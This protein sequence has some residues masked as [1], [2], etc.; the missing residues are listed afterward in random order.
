MTASYEFTNFNLT[1]FVLMWRR[2]CRVH[3]P[4]LLHHHPQPLLVKLL[5]LSLEQH[6]FQPEVEPVQE[7]LT[8]MIVPAVLAYF[9]KRS[10]C[11]PI[12]SNTIRSSSTL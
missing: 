5:G 8:G 9:L 2:G 6:L 3:A 11:D 1:S 10:A 7:N 4:N 12:L